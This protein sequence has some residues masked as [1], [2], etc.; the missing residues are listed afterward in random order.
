MVLQLVLIIFFNFPPTNNNILNHITMRTKL[1]ITVLAISIGATSLLAQSKKSEKDG[2]VFT[3]EKQLKTT[4]VKDQHRSGTCWSFATISFLESELLRMGKGEY[5]LS[6]MFIVNRNYHL[7]ALDYVRFHGKKSFSAGA[8][9]WDVFNVIKQYGLMPEEAYTGNTFGEELPV[10]GEMDAVLKGYLDAVVKNR[11][12]KLTP[13]WK[14]GFDA[15]LDAYLGEIPATFKYKGKEYT[16]K[17]FAKSLGINPDDYINITSFTHHPFYSSFVFEGADNWSL[18]EVY[19]LPIDEM[20][21]VINSA[22]KEGYSIGWGSDVSERGFAFRKGV[23]VMPDTEVK[24][25]DNAEISKWQK[26]SRREKANFGTDYPVKE[27]EITQEMRQID[28]DNYTT[29]ED[30]MMHMVGI[31]KDQNGTTYYLIK[32]SW[33]DDLNNH[34]GYFYASEAFVKFKTVSVLV[35]KK[36]IPKSILKKLNLK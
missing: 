30:H 4:S 3:I 18:G 16:P 28:F 1:F 29:T 33:G 5:D 15:I 10:H 22:I 21:T 12:R 14:K 35:N 7:R 9:G 25:M 32:N 20:M 23:A 26:M 13:V 2:Y 24:N 34:K 6:E 27:K 17:S 31:A 8:E 19:N 36:A 11:N